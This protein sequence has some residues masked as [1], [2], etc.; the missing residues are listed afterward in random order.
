MELVIKRVEPGEDPRWQTLF[1]GAGGETLLQLLERAK[2]ELDPTLTFRFNCASGVCGSCAVQVDGRP[3]LAC[4]YRPQG[5][6]ITVEAIAKVP[7]I[8]DL[9]IDEA[10]LKEKGSLIAM[11][12][13][14]E[15]TR[16]V[17]S[18]AVLKYRL[19][20]QCIEC[21]SCYSVCPVMETNPAF[22]GPFWLT[23]AWRYV[24]DGRE[25][26]GSEKVARIQENGVWDC[27]L[28]GDCIPVCPQGIRPKEDIAFL[29]TKSSTL[30]Y[31]NPHMESFGSGGFGD[32][33][34]G[35]GGFDPSGFTPQG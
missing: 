20:S 19:Q 31:T 9:V 7:V 3:V 15:E 14:G 35:F 16:H 8:R 28:C 30:G 24:N 22:L 17:A 1:V 27:I 23:K 33:G 29:Q 11:A 25:Q 12:L 10:P 18:E 32:F 21:A 2:G 13:T 34:G 26:E 6:R 4:A 5:A